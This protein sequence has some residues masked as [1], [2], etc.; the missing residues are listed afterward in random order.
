VLSTLAELINEHLSGKFTP[1]LEGRGVANALEA[2]CQ[3]IIR[4]SLDR[5]T[6]GHV[7]TVS[8]RFDAI[9][10]GRLFVTGCDWSAN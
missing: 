3:E 6:A 7:S 5:A 4:D 2:A 8:R 1:E 9:D 10:P